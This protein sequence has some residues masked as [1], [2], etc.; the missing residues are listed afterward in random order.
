M[1]AIDDIKVELL[2]T[3]ATFAAL[4]WE[5]L[6]D[7]RYS[8]AFTVRIWFIK[9]TFTFGELFPVFELVLGPQPQRF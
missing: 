5:W 2:P 6:D 9:H 4:L 3:K 7:H 1:A 8:N